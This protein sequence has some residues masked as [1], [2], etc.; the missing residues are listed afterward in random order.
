MNAALLTSNVDP[1]LRPA[2][3]RTGRRPRPVP[4]ATRSPA[5]VGPMELGSH[6]I[7]RPTGRRRRRRRTGVAAP[8]PLPEPAGDL[9]WRGGAGASAEQRGS[10]PVDRRRSPLGGSR[11][12]QRRQKTHRLALTVP[13]EPA[14]G[15]GERA[16]PRDLRLRGGTPHGRRMGAIPIPVHAAPGVRCSAGRAPRSPDG[17]AHRRRSTARGL[18]RRRHLTVRRSLSSRLPGPLAGMGQWRPSAPCPCT[19]ASGKAHGPPGPQASR[20]APAT[21]SAEP[22]GPPHRH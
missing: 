4:S 10:D 17:S 22:G 16:V 9:P 20:P 5:P 19:S 12:D 3:P 21:V 15:L 11:G 2:P 1:F 18:R 8:R 6:D 14:A 7:A 13:A